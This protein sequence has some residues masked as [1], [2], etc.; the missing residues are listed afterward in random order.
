MARIASWISIRPHPLPSH[1][2]GVD[3]PKQ[4]A[5]PSGRTWQVRRLDPEAQTD[6]IL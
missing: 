3:Q 4:I 2:H 6:K 1:R 5:L